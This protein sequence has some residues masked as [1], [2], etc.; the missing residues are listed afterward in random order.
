MKQI[1]L[2]MIALGCLL[3]FGDVIPRPKLMDRY[4]VSRSLDFFKEKRPEIHAMVLIFVKDGCPIVRKYQK[5]ILELS[6]TFRPQGVEIFAVFSN[7][8]DNVSSMNTNVHQQNYP[9]PALYDLRGRLARTLGVTR[10]SE[11]VVLDTTKS[12]DLTNFIYHG[13]I[14]D[15]ISLTGFKAG[16]INEYLGNAL[17]AFLKGGTKNAKQV[18]EVNGCELQFEPEAYKQ[19]K[20]PTV[21]YNQH[22]APILTKKC[23]V[24]HRPDAVAPFELLT[25]DDASNMSSTI[26]RRVRDR[27]MPPW[28]ANVPNRFGGLRHDNRLTED[29]VNTIT[30]WVNQG[31]VEG[32]G[33]APANPAWPHPSEW[34]IGKPDFVYEMPEPMKIPATGVMEY[35]FF[36]VQL[37][38]PKDLWVKK[39][40]I[41]PGTPSIVHHIV[42]HTIKHSST[43]VSGAAL[44]LSLYG[45]TGE[46]ASFF[47]GYVPGDD[48]SSLALSEDEAF[49]VPAGS[50]F[51]FEVHYTPDG[52]ARTDQSKMGLVFTDK[53]PAKIRQAKVYRKPRGSID[54][55]AGD[56]HWGTDQVYYFKDDILLT[57]IYPH[58]HAR[59]KDYKLELINDLGTPKEKAEILMTIPNYDFNWQRTY[60][61]AKP[62]FLKAGTALRATAHWDNSPYNPNN[63]D[64]KRRVPYGIQTFDEMFSTRFNYVVVD[65]PGE[66]K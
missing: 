13:P 16:Q 42:V 45:I 22:V 55:P 38:N 3:S 63:P 36:R 60:T 66:N 26:L 32:P 33:K 15:Q 54:I 65:G 12:V 20:A 39:M 34:T 14:N 1:V 28:H 21:N 35:Q 41:K 53:V 64:P 18:N 58:M 7:E 27:L 51:I 5:K 11:V 25:Y 50:D 24:C 23:Q 49:L 44:M 9:F 48:N 52:T 10:S 29:E 61:L 4:G 56:P 43:A 47:A 2:G 59:G 37:N 30:Q 31:A 62:L 40:Q 6:Q 17:T 57:A 8:A 19:G 46:N